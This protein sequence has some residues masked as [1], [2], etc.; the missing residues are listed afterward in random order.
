MGIPI[1][2]L[3]ATAALASAQNPPAQGTA[4]PQPR[5]GVPGVAYIREN[6]TKF[7]YRIPTRDG[8]KLFTSVYVPKDVFG[9]GRTYPFM[10]VRTPYSIRPYGVDQYP[11]TLGPSE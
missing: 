7:D 2:I 8:V 6:Y 4:A 10:M 11:E 9:D 1:G 3:L 5:P